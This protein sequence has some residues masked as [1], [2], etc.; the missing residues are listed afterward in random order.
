F[1]R[2]F[3]YDA[4]RKFDPVMNLLCRDGAP[5]K[6]RAADRP[7]DPAI[8]SQTFF[9]RI[10]FDFESLI[11]SIDHSVCTVFKSSYKNG[12]NIFRFIF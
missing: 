10:S 4:E 6:L 8:D 2:K 9:F 12:A 7:F 1:Y 5:T 3:L 11:L